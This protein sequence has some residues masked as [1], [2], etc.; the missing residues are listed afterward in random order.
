MHSPNLGS[1]VLTLD[2]GRQSGS[3]NGESAIQFRQNSKLQWSFQV[4]QLNPNAFSINNFAP[5]DNV[6]V[7]NAQP[8]GYAAVNSP[9]KTGQLYLN[10]ASTGDVNFSPRSS[11]KVDPEIGLTTNGLKNTA[12]TGSTQCLRANASGA[13]TG[14]GLPCGSG[15]PQSQLPLS[16]CPPAQLT[17]IPA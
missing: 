13:I 9:G 1:M 10:E 14:T 6:Y 12:I 17:Q 11:T 2:N 7:F 5:G 8:G 15:V 3:V 4:N 16:N